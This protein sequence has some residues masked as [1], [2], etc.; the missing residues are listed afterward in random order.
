MT[1]LPWGF[2][3]HRSYEQIKHSSSFVNPLLGPLHVLNSHC[4]FVALPL[5]RPQAGHISCSQSLMTQELPHLP[6]APICWINA[7]VNKAITTISTNITAKC[8]KVPLHTDL[9]QEIG[10]CPL[11]L[12]PQLRDLQDLG[13][14]ACDSPALSLGFLIFTMRGNYGGKFLKPQ[15]TF[16][17]LSFSLWYQEA[18]NAP[19]SQPHLRTFKSAGRKI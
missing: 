4:L 12:K 7:W 10:T 11:W 5:G 8:S 9:D 17:F 15:N 13:P 3:W 14:W 18:S 2:G 1:I 19:P 6:V 16:P